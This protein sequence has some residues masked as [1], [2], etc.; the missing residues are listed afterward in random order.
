MACGGT[1]SLTIVQCAYVALFE[2]TAV[3]SY[4][5][6]YK[7]VI[8]RFIVVYHGIFHFNLH[9]LG[10]ARVY[11]EKR[12]IISLFHGLPHESIKNR[13]NIR[14]LKMRCPCESDYY[15]D[16]S[17]ATALNWKVSIIMT[18]LRSHLL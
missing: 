5:S 6:W 9:F 2:L 15:V 12:Q 17:L 7:I 8:Q 14:P 4:G 18:I 13:R 16:T 1:H 10:K 11:T 3:F